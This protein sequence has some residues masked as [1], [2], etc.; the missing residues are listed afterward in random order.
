MP[1]AVFALV[2]GDEARSAR[3]DD[4]ARELISQL[5]GRI[6]N[7]LLQFGTRLQ[8]GLP[9]TIDPNLESQ[10]Q[11]SPTL[12]IYTGR[13]LRGEVLITVEGMPDESELSYVGPQVVSEGGGILF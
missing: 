10:R 8:A 1:S 2:K 3:R 7:R 12:R 9:C 13:T 5:M 4:W 6:K 11:R